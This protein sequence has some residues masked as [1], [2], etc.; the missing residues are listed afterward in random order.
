MKRTLIISI[1]RCVGKPGEEWK[2]EVC[3]SD[4]THY[5][6]LCYEPNVLGFG[7]GSL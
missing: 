5:T 7:V 2:R 3:T 1:R 4:K 6:P